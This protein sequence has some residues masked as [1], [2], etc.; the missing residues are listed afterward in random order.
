MK[1][2]IEKLVKEL[3]EKGRVGFSISDKEDPDAKVN[4]WYVIAKL[5]DALLEAKKG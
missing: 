2:A 5:E 3:K 4:V 1:A